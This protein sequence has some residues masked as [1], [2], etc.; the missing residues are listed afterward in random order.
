MDDLFNISTEL[1]AVTVLLVIL[2]GNYLRKRRSPTGIHPRLC[3]AF[4]AGVAVAVPCSCRPFPSSDGV[5][6]FASPCRPQGFL[7]AALS[8]GLYP[9]LRCLP[10]ASS[11]TAVSVCFCL[12]AGLLRLVR[13]MGL[14]RLTTSNRCEELT[15][16]SDLVIQYPRSTFDKET[17][18]GLTVVVAVA[19]RASN[20]WSG[21][22]IGGMPSRARTKH[23]L[24]P[25]SLRARIWWNSPPLFF[26]SVGLKCAEAFGGRL[27]DRW[28]GRNINFVISAFVF[29][30]RFVCVCV[31]VR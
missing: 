30:V 15:R 1:I 13:S 17:W 10:Y 7:A 6:A 25:F 11:C 26:F 18:K 3:A 20:V 14:W 9:P 31:C 29:G 28:I 2:S 21:M 5:K 27:V 8:P 22:Q 19:D 24:S 12:P 23:H 16:M 4:G